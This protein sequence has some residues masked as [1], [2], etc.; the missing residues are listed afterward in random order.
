MNRVMLAGS[1]TAAQLIFTMSHCRK[2]TPFRAS[3][4]DRIDW[5]GSVTQARGGLRFTRQSTEQIK[6]IG[7]AKPSMA[8]PSTRTGEHAS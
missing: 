1:A 4:A 7:I 8:A 2:S 6:I 5:V 3:D